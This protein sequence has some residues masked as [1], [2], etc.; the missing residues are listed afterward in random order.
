MSVFI[1][2]FVLITIRVCFHQCFLIVQHFKSKKRIERAFHITSVIY[3]ES[4]MHNIS[5]IYI[6]SVMYLKS[7]M[8]NMSL[9]YIKSVI[10][11]EIS[12][13]RVI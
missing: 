2:V 5:V 11:I 12:I 6:V 8:H 3:I 4:V 1:N 9:I 7:V 10:Y 13:L